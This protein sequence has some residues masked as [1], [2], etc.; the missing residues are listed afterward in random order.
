MAEARCSAGVA[1]MCCCSKD[2]DSEEDPL[3][4]CSEEERPLLLTR[5]GSLLLMNDAKEEELDDEDGGKLL[6]LLLC[7]GSI[8]GVCVQSRLV[9]RITIVVVVGV[10]V[11]LSFH[12][13]CHIPFYWSHSSRRVNDNFVVR[14]VRANIKKRGVDCDVSNATGLNDVSKVLQVSSCEV[15]SCLGNEQL[16]Y[17][18][19]SGAVRA[20]KFIGTL[21]FFA[22]E[23]HNHGGVLIIVL[24]ASHSLVVY[25]TLKQKVGMI[26]LLFSVD[27]FCRSLC[28]DPRYRFR[29]R[30]TGLDE[31]VFLKRMDQ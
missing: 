21:Y 20:C 10:L 25:E 31:P 4:V 22:L 3:S 28:A 6:L 7:E 8:V 9:L 24:Q 5:E 16:F 30:E 12:V 1:V 2:C 29:I 17:L 11:M 15:Q 27:F 23:T 18:Y 19:K 14:N 13:V 26:V